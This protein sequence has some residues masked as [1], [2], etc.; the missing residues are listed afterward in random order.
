MTKDQSPE[1]AGALA[2]TLFRHVSSTVDWDK[3]HSLND[4]T[5]QYRKQRTRLYRIR[6]SNSVKSIFDLQKTY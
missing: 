6:E 3:K 5:A 1:D 2:S 4:S